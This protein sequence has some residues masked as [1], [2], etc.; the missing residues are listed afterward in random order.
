MGRLGQS[1]SVNTQSTNS[2]ETT[3]DVHILI[4]EFGNITQISKKNKDRFKFYIDPDS[5]QA[6]YV[7]NCVIGIND[8]ADGD[9][10]Y[11]IGLGIGDDQYARAKY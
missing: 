5:P 10:T 11:G 9:C 8:P 1:D 6:D 4:D 2:G 3:K 7:S